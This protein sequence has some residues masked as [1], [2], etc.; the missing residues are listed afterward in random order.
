M[1]WLSKY[2]IADIE[3]LTHDHHLIQ[4]M[5]AHMPSKK[6]HSKAWAEDNELEYVYTSSKVTHTGTMHTHCIKA[7]G[8]ANSN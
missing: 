4:K 1:G 2:Q 8:K 5:L 3:K 6:H 7:I